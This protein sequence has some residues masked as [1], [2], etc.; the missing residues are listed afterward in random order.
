MDYIRTDAD[1]QLVLT[2]ATEDF[3]IP[4]C[5]YGMH[6]IETT[7]SK[8]K[9][10]QKIYVF[11]GKMFLEEKDRVCPHCLKKGKEVRMHKHGNFTVTLKH[12]SMFGSLAFVRYPRH[13]LKCPV[14]GCTKSQY[15]PFKADGHMIT[16]ELLNYAKSLLAYGFTNK[17]VSW[18]TGINKDA[19]K[20]IDFTDLK[21][22]FT[23]DGNGRKLMMPEKQARYL[24]IDEFKLH[25]G[26]Q[27]ATHIIDL[28][29]GYILW[30]AIGKKK[31]VVYDF[32]R[33]VGLEWMKGVE[34]VACDMNSDFEEAFR[35][36]CEWITVVFD[37]FHI[38]KNF[39]DMVISAVRK[40]EQDRLKKAGDEEGYRALKRTK[41]LMMSSRKT[42]EKKDQQDSTGKEPSSKDSVF[43]QPKRTR[44][45]NKTGYMERY[46]DLIDANELFL[47]FDLIKGKLLCAYDLTDVNKMTSAMN[48]I[49]QLCKDTNNKHFEKFGRLIENHFDGIVAHA[50]YRISSG[51]IEG[52][53]NKIKTLRRQGYGYPD[54]EYF[55]FKIIQASRRE[56]VKN[57][58]THKISD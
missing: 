11:S 24:A 34:A 1:G 21:E 53:N 29:T 54:D 31:Q 9:T 25:N 16:V 4:C 45:T 6:D 55:F 14:C 28:E 51:K 5:L 47:A 40:D 39:N 22:R 48:E 46:K 26:Y 7:V 36:K 27:Y 2:T 41:Y 38:V 43:A 52:I 49:I 18:L 15:I 17:E 57:P 10:K 33:H 32:I 23:A 50:R 12:L 44:R 19:V 37:H 8:T 30:I 42:L 56:Y 13:E 35:D 3:R 58:K 20:D